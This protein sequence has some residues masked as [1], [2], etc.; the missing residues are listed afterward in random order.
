M[1]QYILEL[2]VGTILS[3]SNLWE[4]CWRYVIQYAAQEGSGDS[5]GLPQADEIV[6]LY[7]D[8]YT[9]KEII[10]VY[11][12]VDFSFSL[13]SAIISLFNSLHPMPV[14]SLW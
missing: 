8:G 12:K 9:A 4:V 6:R 14:R 10:V 2:V 1:H 5:P 7:Q 3:H 11:K 13:E